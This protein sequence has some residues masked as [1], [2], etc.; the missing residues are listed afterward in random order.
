M[1]G[2]WRIIQ[3]VQK[4]VRELKSREELIFQ[5]P[6][7]ISFPLSFSV[8]QTLSLHNKCQNHSCVCDIG[9]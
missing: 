3:I 1:Y 8:C 9:N 5:E 6:P 2:M 7:D 4:L